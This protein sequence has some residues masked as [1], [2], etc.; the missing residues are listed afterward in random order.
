MLRTKKD[1]DT[2]DKDKIQMFSKSLVRPQLEYCIQ[3]W[4]PYLKLDM[5]KLE[6]LERSFKNYLGLQRFK[7]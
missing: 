4:N 5:K 3:V 7:L 1:T 2:I 6:K